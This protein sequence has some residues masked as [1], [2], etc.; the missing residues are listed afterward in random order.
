MVAQRLKISELLKSLIPKDEDELSLLQFILRC[1]V[2]LHRPFQSDLALGVKTS[3]CVEVPTA[4]WET[5]LGKFIE[6]V[7]EDAKKYFYGL[8]EALEIYQSIYGRSIPIQNLTLSDRSVRE[9]KQIR[10][11]CLQDGLRSL[12]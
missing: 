4:D 8:V 1:A 7:P 10:D 3:V 12:Y 9:L 11:Y 2:L 6:M 5:D